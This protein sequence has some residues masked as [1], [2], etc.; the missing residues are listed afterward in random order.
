MKAR[1]KDKQKFKE[2]DN[3]ECVACH[4]NP[5]PGIK[6]SA[7]G[8]TQ[9]FACHFNEKEVSAKRPTFATSCVGCHS[10]S[11][12]TK[13]VGSELAVLRFDRRIVEPVKPFKTFSHKTHE[14]AMGSNTKACMECHAT[15]KKAER[16]SDFYSPDRR[17]KVAQPRSEACV[18][19]HRKEMQTKITAGQQFASAK[20]TYCHAVGTLEAA[21]KKGLELPP[22]SHFYK[23]PAG[24]P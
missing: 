6:Q 19:C 23:K 12:S 24:T 1:Y 10:A 14:E 11:K 18:E 9:C 22:Q 7:P 13:N 21:A 5:A 2:R 16:L 17:T 15:A 3:F 4:E 20:C 8:H